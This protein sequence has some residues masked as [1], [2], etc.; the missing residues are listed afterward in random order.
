MAFITIIAICVTGASYGY[1]HPDDVDI[2]Q[3]G[4]KPERYPS[5]SDKQQPQQEEQA[6]WKS[7]LDVRLN[8]VFETIQEAEVVWQVPPNPVGTL[9]IAHGCTH[10]ATDFWPKGESCDACIGLPEETA[11]V[12]AALARKFAV[13]AVSSAD[14]EGKISKCWAAPWPPANSTADMR[15][16]P[17]ALSA[18][19]LQHKLNKLPLYALGASS[20]GFFVSVLAHVVQLDAAAIYISGGVAN[21]YTRHPYLN[22]MAQPYPPTLFVHMPRDTYTAE[23]V[24]MAIKAIQ[25]LDEPDSSSIVWAAELTCSP[26]PIT[27]RYFADRCD[28][29]DSATSVQ[30]YN[31]LKEAGF[32]DDKNMLINNP[33]HLDWQSVL[34]V[35]RGAEA[36][37]ATQ[38]VH[39]AALIELLN[40]AY[41]SHE[42]TRDRAPQT[43]DWFE[44]KCML[45]GVSVQQRCSSYD[46]NGIPQSA[47]RHTIPS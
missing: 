14:R 17:A 41:G 15:R 12:R 37:H 44:G 16:V 46:A 38:I 2:G 39:P 19:R 34:V 9:F 1:H 6:S 26:Q 8:G 28:S 13:I 24:H 11:L 3:R 27:P 36:V 18:W 10:G 7:V 42:L 5:S 22:D 43:F 25:Q 32:L 4:R 21:A 40:V 35:K 33:R 29:I 47:S 30:L 31:C 20:G 23:G 45:N